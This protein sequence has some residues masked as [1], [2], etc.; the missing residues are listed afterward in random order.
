MKKRRAAWLVVLAAG[1]L[2]LAPR[3]KSIAEGPLTDARGAPMFFVGSGGSLDLVKGTL[4]DPAVRRGRRPKEEAKPV[5]QPMPELKDALSGLSGASGAAVWGPQFSPTIISARRRPDGT[6]QVGPPPGKAFS[7]GSDPRFSFGRHDSARPEKGAQTARSAGGGTPP[8]RNMPA[9]RAP[10]AEPVPEGRPERRARSAD[11]FDGRRSAGSS[12]RITKETSL[13]VTPWSPKPPKKEPEAKEPRPLTLADWI[14]KGAVKAPTGK[15]EAP[16]FSALRALFPERLPDGRSYERGTPGPAVLEALAPPEERPGY[17]DWL[18]KDE[19]R[20]RKAEPHWH[21]DGKDWVFHAGKAW[22]LTAE[23]RWAWMVEAG[24]RWW[25]VA[26]GAQRMVR[27]Q[28]SWWWKTKDGWFLL[29]GGE[30]WAWRHFPE[31]EGDGVIHPTRGTQV[32]YSADGERVAV[33]TPG[34]DTQVFDART[35]DL[36]ASFPP[37]GKRAS[38]PDPGLYGM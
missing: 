15:L 14:G 31:W 24:R 5:L 2:V 21:M 12:G 9:A 19:R 25:T 18:D 16:S 6:T 1:A 36:L 27:H 32:V 11:D 13:A 20:R 38:A 34:Q 35:G 29:K 8:R 26:D 7:G 4:F 23:G 37:E 3:L 30:P 28:D 22:G 33:I 17:E 10:E